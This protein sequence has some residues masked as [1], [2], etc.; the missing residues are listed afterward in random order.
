[1]I[2]TAIRANGKVLQ[3]KDTPVRGRLSSCV[4]GLLCGPAAGQRPAAPLQHY[5]MHGHDY[6]L[7][8]TGCPPGTQI[9]GA[10]L[11][12]DWSAPSRLGGQAA[13]SPDGCQP[14]TQHGRQPSVTHAGK[15]L[16]VA[17]QLADEELV[18]SREHCQAEAPVGRP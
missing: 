8:S 1:M 3:V 5:Q 10:L 9:G 12:A 16:G 6:I 17:D 13:K 14:G 2:Q 7:S 4:V 11:D 18:V 15:V